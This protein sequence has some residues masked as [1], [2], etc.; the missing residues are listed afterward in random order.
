[1]GTLLVLVPQPD[2]FTLK[3]FTAFWFLG[4]ATLGIQVV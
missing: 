2:I 3:L 1:M 4:K